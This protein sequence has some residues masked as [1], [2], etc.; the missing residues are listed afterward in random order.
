MRNLFEAKFVY[1]SHMGENPWILVAHSHWVLC[2][3]NLDIGLFYF[4]GKIWTTY[5][6]DSLNTNP[7]AAICQNGRKS[8][9]WWVRGREIQDLTCNKHLSQYDLPKKINIFCDIMSVLH[10]TLLMC[11]FFFF[12]FWCFARSKWIGK[13]DSMMTVLAIKRSG[14]TISHLILEAWQWQCETA[15]CK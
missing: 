6:Q 5:S 3:V 13:H 4:P 12:F 15:K 11:K 14:S 10:P 9:F 2:P 1:G 7:I 8:W